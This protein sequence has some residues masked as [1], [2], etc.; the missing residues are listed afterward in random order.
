MPDAPPAAAR[1]AA[2]EWLVAFAAIAAGGVGYLAAVAPLWVRERAF[3]SN[4]GSFTLALLLLVC[5]AIPTAGAGTWAAESLWHRRATG[6][7]PL[8]VSLGGGYA[9][10]FLAGLA[11]AAF[12]VLR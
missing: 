8:R 7:A 6:A 11:V 5:L 9:G 3:G 1:T 12:F 2:A 10:G 4:C